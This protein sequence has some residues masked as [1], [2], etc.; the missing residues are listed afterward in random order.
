MRRVEPTRRCVCRYDP[1]REFGRAGVESKAEPC[2]EQQRSH[3]AATQ[4]RPDMKAVNLPRA[5]RIS[6]AVERRAVGTEAEQFT[7]P[8]GEVDMSRRPR[9]SRVPLLGTRIHVQRCEVCG[10]E[11]GAVCHTPARDVQLRNRVRVA[12]VSAAQPHARNSRCAMTI[13]AR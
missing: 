12:R 1:E 7:V 11:L 6:V 4:L 9:D 13:A 5:R 3:A 8:L 10:R 2:I